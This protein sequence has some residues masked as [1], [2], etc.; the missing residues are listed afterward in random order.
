MPP[1]TA[2]GRVLRW[3]P[4]TYWQSWLFAVLGVTLPS[5]IVFSVLG[6]DKGWDYLVSRCVRLSNA[7]D[8]SRTGF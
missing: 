8:R 6:A 5:L 3:H 4:R 7:A 2:V 1:L